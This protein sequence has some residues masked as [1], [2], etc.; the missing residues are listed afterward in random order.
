MAF[1]L[2]LWGE[3]EKEEEEGEEEEEEEELLIETR[4]P[5]PHCNE[6][7]RNFWGVDTQKTCI[8]DARAIVFT[9]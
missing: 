4:P 2:W 6:V 1:P 5:T 9:R 8:C 7:R 3:E